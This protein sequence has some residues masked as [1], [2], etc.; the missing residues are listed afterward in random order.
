MI[1][2]LSVQGRGLSVLVLRAKRTRRD[3][4]RLLARINVEGRLNTLSLKCD[5]SVVQ[6]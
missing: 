2:D 1:P 3:V 5:A 4:C 6:S